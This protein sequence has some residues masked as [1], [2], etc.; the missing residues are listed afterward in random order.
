MK[1]IVGALNSCFFSPEAGCF[2]SFISFICSFSVESVFPMLCGLW[3][4]CLFFKSF[5]FL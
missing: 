2:A 4:L 1:Y 5:C 3:C